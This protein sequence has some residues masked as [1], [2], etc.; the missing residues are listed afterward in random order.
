MEQA[1]EMQLISSFISWCLSLVTKNDDPECNP[2][3][4]EEDVLGII[5]GV[6][7]SIVTLGYAGWSATADEKLSARRCVVV[8]SCIGQMCF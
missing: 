8:H 4:G 7:L 6:G 1:I 3:L 2:F 5:I